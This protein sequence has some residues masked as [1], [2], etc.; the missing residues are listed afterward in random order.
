MTIPPSPERRLFNIFAPSV[1]YVA[2]ENDKGERNIG[3]CFHIGENVFITA[4]HM[5]EN[6][7]ITK[8]ATTVG[9]IDISFGSYIPRETS[10]IEGLFFHPNPNY[11][12]AALKLSELSGPQVPP[13]PVPEIQPDHELLLRPVVVMGYPPIPGSKSPVLFCA[14]GEVNASFVTYFDDQRILIISCMA[15]G[16]FSGG[17]VFTPPHHFLGVVTRSVL[18]ISQ[19]EEL[20]FMAVVG[21]WPIL[22]LLNHHNIMPRYL[23]DEMWTP[24]QKQKATNR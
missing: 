3:T 24:A 17:P 10:R 20:G 1:A 18:K 6:Y 16:G 22:E 2:V 14:T 19:P 8:I 5:V 23:R 12:L 4:R 21:T 11:D 13:L 9:S 7:T 15:R